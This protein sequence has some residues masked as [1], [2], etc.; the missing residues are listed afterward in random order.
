MDGRVD[1]GDDHLGDQQAPSLVFYTGRQEM[2]SDV[3]ERRF[4]LIEHDIDVAGSRCFVHDEQM[5]GV[6]FM[7]CHE[8]VD[9]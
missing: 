3:D 9:N 2:A 6:K 5:K 7:L 4:R 8:K 1:G